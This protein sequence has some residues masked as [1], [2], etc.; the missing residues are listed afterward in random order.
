MPQI[1]INTSTP[2][3]ID[4]INKTTINEGTIKFYPKEGYSLT[5]VSGCKG[6]IE[7][8]TLIIQNITNQE[9]C[10]VTLRKEKITLKEQLLADNPTILT[11]TDFSQ[12]FIETNT[13]TLYKATGNLTEG[14]KDVYYFAGNAQNNWIKFGKDQ[15]DTD[16]Y[17][18]IIRTNEDGGVRLLYI[19]PDKA[20]TT[21]FIKL[22]EQNITGIYNSLYKD[23]M[24]VGY[25]Y[26]STG[27]LAN[28]RQNTTSAPIKIITDNWYSRTINTKTD[29]TYA[30]NKYVSQTAIYC[31]DRAGDG[32]IASGRMYYAAYRRLVDNKKPSHRCGNNP[33][34][35]LYGDNSPADKFT[36][37]STTGNGKLTYP[38]AQITADE[39]VV[40]IRSQ[41]SLLLI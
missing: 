24:Y 36:K 31:N 33:S 19:G 22:D 41:F 16:L 12:P 26:G 7:N 14:G 28:N 20:T 38:I 13:G 30:Y 18:R 40:P 3:G 21:A 4:S 35:T 6:T 17:W 15:D 39:V 8:N 37:S 2:E 1:K 25:M 29:G 34:G 10:N 23:T 27:S 9:T 32:Y 11:R 5:E